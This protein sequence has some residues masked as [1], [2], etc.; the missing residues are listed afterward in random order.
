MAVLATWAPE[1][2]T[3]GAIAPL[4]LAC[5]AGTALVVDLDPGGPR[6]PGRTLAELVDDGPTH[7]ELHPKRRGVAVMANGGID[8]V[9]ASGVLGALMDTWPNVV[10]RLPSLRVHDPGVG[11]VPVFPLSPLAPR[12]SGPAVYQRSLWRMNPPG[13]GLLLP[14][15]A[16]AT[17][18]ALV[19]G[20]RPGP[21]RWIRAWA[22]VWE[23]PWD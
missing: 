2:G 9:D 21:S 11:T 13:P 19:R 6:Y 17:I 5:A 1:D 20:T 15:P 14:R 8:P 12:P 7:D 3:L 10:L 18:R 16:A 4:A 23:A 22:D